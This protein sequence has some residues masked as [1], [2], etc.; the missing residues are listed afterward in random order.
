[1]EGL[2]DDSGI[3]CGSNLGSKKAW[4]ASVNVDHVD[5]VTFLT[6]QLRNCLF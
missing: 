4:S 6:F 3:R 5:R 2:K 1:M